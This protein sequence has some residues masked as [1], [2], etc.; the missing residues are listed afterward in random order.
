M[1]MF[2]CIVIVECAAVLMFV[3]AHLRSLQ[4]EEEKTEDTDLVDL[5]VGSIANHLHQLKDTCWILEVTTITWRRLRR[6]NMSD[7]A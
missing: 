2:L 5:T 3:N 4:K 1:Q 6:G 7:V